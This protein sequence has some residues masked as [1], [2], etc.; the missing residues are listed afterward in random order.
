MTPMMFDLG[1]PHMYT[2]NI[3]GGMDFDRVNISDRGIF[4][5]IN[6][7]VDVTFTGTGTSSNPYVVK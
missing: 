6:L 5:V 2:V 7:R 1:Q 3:D 4:P